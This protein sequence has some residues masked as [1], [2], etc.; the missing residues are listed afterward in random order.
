MGTGAEGMP[1]VEV[2]QKPDSPETCQLAPSGAEPAARTVCVSAPWCVNAT[3]G[4]WFLREIA[5]RAIAQVPGRNV[6]DSR[7]VREP[8]TSA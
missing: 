6:P 3:T 5:S 2:A 4:D 7:A 8:M 1:G